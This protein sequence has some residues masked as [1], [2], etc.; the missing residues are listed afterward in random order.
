MLFLSADVRHFYLNLKGKM[1]MKRILAVL[2]SA[3]MVLSLFA[4]GALA[5]ADAQGG[6]VVP[7]EA[8]SSDP[9]SFD[10][11][12]LMKIDP[13]PDFHFH[14]AVQSG[15]GSGEMGEDS[16]IAWEYYMAQYP[17]TNAMY[18]E[19]LDATGADAPQY[20]E[21]GNYPEGKANHPVLYVSYLDA[22]AYC[23]W[24]SEKY[25]AWTFRL[26]TEAEWENACYAPAIPDHEDYTYPWGNETGMTY[27]AETGEFTNKYELACNALL[28][29]KILDPNGEYGPDYVLT[30]VKDQLAG[31][32]MTVGE[33]LTMSADGQSVQTWAN[34]SSGVGFIFTDLYAEFS[35]GGG[36]TMPVDVGYVNP[37]G[38]YG[39]AGNVWCWTNSWVV[40][41]NGA[42]AG[43]LVRSVR[44]GS[45]YATTRSCSVN[46]RGEGRLET[47]AFHTI[48]F[49]VAATPAGGYIPE[50]TMP[51]NV[52]QL[53][54]AVTG[55]TVDSYALPGASGESSFTVPEG[56]LEQQP[57]KLAT[58]T[59]DGVETEPVPGQT[60][61][62][63]VEITYTDAFDE[64]ISSY[65]NRGADDYR[66][67]LY[68][69]E[70]GLDEDNS[71]LSAIQDHDGAAVWNDDGASN[72]YIHSESDGF[73]AVIV[74]NGSYTV[75]N[76]RFE[77]LTDSDGHL[78]TEWTSGGGSREMSWRTDT[79]S[80]FS[81]LGAVVGA[82]NDS[83]VTVENADIET[84]GV[85][86][87]TLYADKGSDMVLTDSAIHA[88]GGVIYDGYISTADQNKMV[89]PP[90]VLGITGNARAT[91]MEGENTSF[92][93]SNVDASAKQWGVLSTDAGK[94]M[95]MVVI[96]STLTLTGADEDD[97]PF[98]DNWGSGY[99]TYLIGS[100]GPAKEYFYGVTFNVGT[101]ASISTGG[102]AVYASSD[103]T[104]DKA[105]KYSDY[106]TENLDP[107][108]TSRV[109]SEN[110]ALAVYAPDGS[111]NGF[112]D[113]LVGTFAGA[114]RPTI[115]N[116]DG[117]GIMTHS[118]G[119]DFVLTDGTQF[120]TR[121]AAFLL[122]GGDSTILVN[123]GSELNAADGVLVQMIDNDDT[124]V[125]VQMGVEHYNGPTFNTVYEEAEGWPG[126]DYEVIGTEGTSV[127]DVHFDHVKLT[128]DLYN[129]TGYYSSTPARRLEV[130]LGEDTEL[131]GAVSAT[132]T[133]HVDE[134]GEQICRFTQDEYYYL[135]H[136]ANKP[137]H[138]GCNDVCVTLADNAVWNV[139][140]EGILTELTIGEDAVFNG[141]LSVDGREISAEPGTYSGR[142][143][144]SPLAGN[145]AS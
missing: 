28:A 94:N 14:T 102:A 31:Q 53:I 58:M 108:S 10:P 11:S 45:W 68:V 136:M 89:A 60:Y 30:Y 13:N 140:A 81:G 144:V 12:Q 18:K 49:R 23:A 63:V 134:N 126:I 121:N 16:P 107:D 93:V 27:D 36:L 142:I 78:D 120:N 128:G 125:G 37:Y 123:D 39:C 110:G 85:A 47:G 143:I 62:G 48:G 67:A 38:L 139:T 127:T 25:P 117:F 100:N 50:E 69:T 6:Y 54:D 73:S 17:V 9:I 1:K 87:L 52:D 55:A 26:P 2:L 101:F 91:N 70:N 82:F 95:Q 118:N 84:S 135:G 105:A 112:A 19:Y 98:I 111:V 115:V 97:N 65:T 32:T 77:F 129:A 64:A 41:T 21:N 51:D 20:W 72:L 137:Y 141:T 90:W 61:S 24:L 103:F 57:G 46:T 59:V 76:A 44:G 22:E 86:K 40:A 132:S 130:Y 71:V 133:V 7:A 131:T 75:D 113:A 33:L 74:N 42:E 43:Q 8:A 145:A 79:I 99:G 83:Y 3:C 15:G 96:D 124:L 92:T 66:A 56:G 88:D 138:N 114:G 5:S 104:E 122:K 4:T 34:H 29:A 35:E 116:S 109:V 119:G 80:D 106:I